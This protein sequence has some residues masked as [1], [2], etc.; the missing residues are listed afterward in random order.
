M[1]V[2]VVVCLEVI[3][4]DENDLQRFVVALRLQPQP[5]GQVVEHPPVVQAAQAVAFGDVVQQPVLDE[6]GAHEALHSECRQ[7]RHQ[8]RGEHHRRRENQVVARYAQIPA[9]RDES[10]QHGRRDD[11]DGAEQQAEEQRRIDDDEH[12]AH[13]EL[14]HAGCGRES[15]DDHDAHARDDDGGARDPL[16]VSLQLGDHRGR[17][18]R[19]E[20]RTRD[21]QPQQVNRLQD[22]FR[23]RRHRAAHVDGRDDRHEREVD[24]GGPPCARQRPLHEVRLELR[25]GLRSEA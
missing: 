15:A 13:L 14:R 7:H 23:E 1:T 2:Q 12:V 19:D 25:L 11:H 16:I 9:N 8:R 22:R 17:E 24:G 18:N 20:R 21:A 4:I 5:I 10:E 3:D 6:V